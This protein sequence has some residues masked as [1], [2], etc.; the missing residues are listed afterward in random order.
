MVNFGRKAPHIPV[1]LA[2]LI[3]WGS[4]AWGLPAEGPVIEGKADVAVA[5]DPAGKSNTY[6]WLYAGLGLG[7]TGLSANTAFNIRYGDYVAALGATADTS[8]PDYGLSPGGEDWY[9]YDIGLL[10]GYYPFRNIRIAGGVAWVLAGRFSG[11]PS[12]Y[13][14]FHSVGVPVEFEFSPFVGRVA[15]IGIVGHADFNKERI[16]GGVTVGMELG[17]LK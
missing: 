7:S 8:L 14:G 16:F 13:K 17:K 11:T 5:E 15:G 1:V 6:S 3:L 10:L 2:S 9:L 12:V 4:F